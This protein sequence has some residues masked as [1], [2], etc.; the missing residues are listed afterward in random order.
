MRPQPRAARDHHSRRETASERTSMTHPYGQYPEQQPQ[1]YYG[2]FHPNSSGFP[3]QTPSAPHYGH[4][5]YG[6]PGYPTPGRTNPLAV[7]AL[8]LSLLPLCG[9]SWIGAI[10]CGHIARKQIREKGEQ[11]AGMALAGLI[12]GYGLVGLCALY[13]VVG[14]VLAFIGSQN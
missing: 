11:G 13:V 8:V 7:I 4:P 3:A 12:I 10:V 14:G 1:Q 6:H 5:G 2:S 9:L